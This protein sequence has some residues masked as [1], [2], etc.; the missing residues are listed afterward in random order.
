MRPPR[1]REALTDLL[2]ALPSVLGLL[3]AVLVLLR[4]GVKSVSPAIN[5]F[6]LLKPR[7]VTEE[8]IPGYAG[9]R[10]T[11]EFDMAETPD[12]RGR[13]RSLFVYLR[14]TAAVIE[15]DGRVYADTGEWENRR[16][17]GHTPGN[18]W[19]TLPIYAGYGEKVIRVTLTPVYDSV[20]DL[21]PLFLLID[22]E[23]LINL[24]LLPREGPLLA[25]GAVTVAAGVFLALLALALGL[26]PQDRR[27]VFYLGAVAVA[28]GLWKLCGLPVVP[29]LLD[30]YGAQKAIWFLGMAAYL[31]MTVFSLRLLTL[32]RGDGN[33]RV[34]LGCC[35]FA[36]A[37]ALGLLVL[38]TAGAVELHQ[39]AVWYG[40]G[41]ASLHLLALLGRRPGRS[42][43]L[44]ALPASLA[45]GCDLA[46]YLIGGSMAP[47]SAF[48]VWIAGNLLFRGLGFLRAAIRRERELQVKNDE[49][50]GARMKALIQQIQPHFIY[51]TL[52]TIH[53]ICADDPKQAMRVISDFS[54][55][56]HA[57]FDALSATEPIL[58]TRE[59]EH[60]RAY[61]GVETAR[62]ADRLVV[63]YQTD[64]ITFR[65]PPLTLQPI[66]EN[67][68]KHGLRKTRRP[69][70][71][72]ITTRAVDGGAEIVV[73]DNGVG[74]DPAP[75]GALHIGLRNVR[76][77]L[78]MMCDGTLDIEPRSGGGTVVTVFVPVKKQGS[79]QRPDADGG[80]SQAV[81]FTKDPKEN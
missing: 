66:V 48:L 43:L 7:S 5:P 42:E 65:R 41:M 22:R 4:P 56:L 36:A 77:R 51:N 9:V 68:V 75:N 27:R 14:H 29:L 20:R 72:V 23:P 33:S 54:D 8:M 26:E 34:G 2:I 25:L 1:R 55:Y 37:A 60:T 57:N 78:E 44:W 46:V 24:A 63:D 3:A 70:H 10:R 6:F 32:L 12:N 59:L 58:F 40:A 69:E 52:A 80:A 35:C 50:R 39:A 64:Y 28:A 62:Y 17:I 53:M 73:K 81:A 61:L 67:S 15:M 38:Q 47:A 19:L 71:I 79:G 30:Y 31:L 13:G 76:E 21:Q 45:L 74:Y 16:H 49:L 18:Y 11:Y